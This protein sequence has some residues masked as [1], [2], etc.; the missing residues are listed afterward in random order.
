MLSG[1]IE[2]SVIWQVPALKYSDAISYAVIIENDSCLVA[3][4]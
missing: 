1:I 4:L 3:L 2:P